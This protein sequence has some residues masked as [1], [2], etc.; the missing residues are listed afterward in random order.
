MKIVIENASG[1]RAGHAADSH[2]RRDA[3]RGVVGDGAGLVEVLRHKIGGDDED[4]RIL[5]AVFQ[6][7]EKL[8]R[9]GA[10]VARRFV[11]RVAAVHGLTGGFEDH[12]HADQQYE[13]DEEGDHDFDQSESTAGTPLRTED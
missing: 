5:G 10:G 9:D 1:H 8:R 6:I 4:R 2:D 7:L 11:Q 3:G 13:G 12:V